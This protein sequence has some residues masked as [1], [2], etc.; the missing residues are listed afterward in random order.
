M[1]PKIIRADE[2]LDIGD[3]L[4]LRLI[5]LARRHQCALRAPSV[6]EQVALQVDRLPLQLL[7]SLGLQQVEHLLARDA[8]SHF[9]ELALVLVE[10][11]GGW[12]LLR[13][14]LP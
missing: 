6:V 2:I 5:V 9:E 3:N 12:R 14:G 8:V 4:V 1:A 13:T 7:E 10:Q 11:D